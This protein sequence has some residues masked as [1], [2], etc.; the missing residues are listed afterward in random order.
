MGELV[1]FMAIAR[2]KPSSHRPPEGGAE[3]VFFTG[4][5]YER[6]EPPRSEPKPARRPALRTS[7]PKGKRNSA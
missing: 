5:R 3:I 4:V 6:A 2:R 1:N 7:K